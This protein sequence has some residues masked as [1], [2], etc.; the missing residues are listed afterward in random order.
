MTP[1]IRL[2][3]FLSIVGIVIWGSGALAE[4]RGEPWGRTAMAVGLT[5]MIV[6]VLMR[7]LKPRQ[8]ANET[9]PRDRE[10]GAGG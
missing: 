8:E 1:I 4:R 6:S 7:F 3:L 9:A 5:I 10:P 2:R